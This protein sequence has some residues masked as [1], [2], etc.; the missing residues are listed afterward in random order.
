MASLLLSLF[1]PSSLAT[2]Q[3][4]AS[5]NGAAL[6][7]VDSKNN[8]PSLEQCTQQQPNIIFKPQT[9][10]DETEDGIIFLHRWANAIHIDTKIVTLENG[11]C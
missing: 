9:I 8:T 3:V 11:I 7:S 6:S 4:V 5:E 2:E 10:F 1:S